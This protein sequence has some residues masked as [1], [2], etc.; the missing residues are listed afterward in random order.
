MRLKDKV[1]V[2]TGAGA[3]LGRECALLF[4]K[5]GA[6]VVATDVEG[7]RAEAVAKEIGAA[8]IGMKVDVVKEAEL[9]AAV[10]AAVDKWGR[11][12]VMFNNA[13]IA[14][15]GFGR[16]PFEE[17]TEESFRKVIDVNLLGVVLGCKAAIPQMKAQ[18]GGAILNTS[19]ASAFVGFANYAIYGATKGAV[20]ALTRNLALDLGP[21]GIRV[22]TICP[23]YGMSPNFQQGTEAEVIGRSYEEVAGE[24]SP[25]ARRMPLR[26]DRPPSLMDNAYAALYLASDEAAYQSGVCLQT[27]DGGTLGRVAW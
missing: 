26:L 9:Q 1:V 11:L 10:K 4:A 15:V 24:W 20:N 3:G 18:G 6:R 12:D 17:T 14:V 8:A 16:V 7:S 21:Y 2:I 22:N 25:D 5:E 27:T 23:L 19:S 13:G